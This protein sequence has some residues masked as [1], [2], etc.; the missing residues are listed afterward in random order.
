[1]LF[2]SSRP[3]IAAGTSEERFADTPEPHQSR[4][5]VVGWLSPIGKGHGAAEAV[6][7]RAITRGIVQR[8]GGRSVCAFRGVR[9]SGQ[10]G[11]ST[12]APRGNVEARFRLGVATIAQSSLRWINTSA[13]AEKKFWSVIARPR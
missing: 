7:G 2:K 3:P 8:E 6:G 13:S 1:M 10:R 9:E 4:Q 11:L 5:V 12:R